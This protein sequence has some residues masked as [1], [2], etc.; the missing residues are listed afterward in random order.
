MEDC[1]T[2]LFM[3][4]TP[5]LHVVPDEAQMPPMAPFGH[6][7]QYEYPTQVFSVMELHVHSDDAA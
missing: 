3:V 5:Q 4:I 2:Q 6:Q 1:A 7:V